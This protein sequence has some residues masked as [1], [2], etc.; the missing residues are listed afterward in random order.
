MAALKGDISFRYLKQFFLVLIRLEVAHSTILKKHQVRS[1]FLIPIQYRISS[2]HRHCDRMVVGF[3]TIYASS[4]WSYGSWIYNYF[5]NQCLISSL[6]LGVGIPL[7]VRCTG[8]NICQWLTTGLWF[9]PG[10]PV[11]S[12]NKTDRD[13]I[14]EI[15]LKVALNTIALTPRI[16]DWLLIPWMS[17][18]A[19]YHIFCCMSNNS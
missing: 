17:N 5:C 15:L 3:T 14:T 13:Y 16:I 7:M 8:Y 11:S 4:L 19:Y 1:L 9:S 2:G 6:K 10:T 18:N 12:T